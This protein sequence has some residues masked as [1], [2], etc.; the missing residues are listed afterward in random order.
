MI[1]SAK[2]LEKK[3]VYVY[4]LVDSYGT[5]IY[6]GTAVNPVS[7]MTQHQE[8]SDMLAKPYYMEITHECESVAEAL[9]IEK[10]LHKSGFN[11][12]CKTSKRDLR[13]AS[14]TYEIK[15]SDTEVD[16]IQKM[17]AAGMSYSQI[18]QKVGLSS[19]Q[20]YYRLNKK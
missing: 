16:R 2:L 1:K 3:R 5:C 20:V 9:S 17:K 19:N 12:R 6:V 4:R 7:R 13:L 11:G 18:G 10:C 14:I 15:S 8:E